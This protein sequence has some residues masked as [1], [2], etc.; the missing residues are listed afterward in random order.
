MNFIFEYIA[1]FTLNGNEWNQMFRDSGLIND[2]EK[3]NSLLNYADSK[4]LSL[5]SSK[6]NR[7]KRLK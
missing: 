2:K 4:E 6:Q 5:L 1:V 3:R 7:R